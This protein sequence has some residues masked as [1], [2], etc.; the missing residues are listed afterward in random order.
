[1]RFPRSR[2]MVLA[3]DPI[4]TGF[5]YELC[6]DWLFLMSQGCFRDVSLM[7]YSYACEFDGSVIHT[8]HRGA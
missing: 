2:E 5:G 7:R 1:M 6:F 8:G 4:V 3:L